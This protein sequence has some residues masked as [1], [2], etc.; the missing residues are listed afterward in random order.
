MKG[1]VSSLVTINGRLD[2]LDV[3]VTDN[4][5]FVVQL[6]VIGLRVVAPLVLWHVLSEFEFLRSNLPETP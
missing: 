1:T 6:P 5:L 2:G 4:G 3:F